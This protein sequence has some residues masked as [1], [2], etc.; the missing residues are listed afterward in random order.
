MKSGDKHVIKLN[1]ENA[2]VLKVMTE[3][4]FSGYKKTNDLNISCF[5]LD[6]EEHTSIAIILDDISSVEYGFKAVE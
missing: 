2:P 5:E 3:V 6:N 1:G 4:V